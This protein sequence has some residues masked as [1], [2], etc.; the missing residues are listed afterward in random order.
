M[1]DAAP[2]GCLRLVGGGDRPQSVILAAIRH[3]IVT[4]NMS[5]VFAL[6]SVFC[7][8]AMETEHKNV[9]SVVHIYS[10][11]QKSSLPKT[12]CD[13]FTPGEPV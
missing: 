1:G 12:F 11:S 6:I 7:H 8:S 13:I 9:D 10:V 3:T 2:R 4:A 5:S